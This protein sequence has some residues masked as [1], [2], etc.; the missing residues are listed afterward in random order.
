LLVWLNTVFPIGFSEKDLPA[1]NPE[2]PF[3]TESC[4]APV[5]SKIEKVY[6]VKESIE[7]PDS[8]KWL[9]RN[10]MLDALDRLWQ[11]H[12]YAMD[13]LRSSVGLRAY[14]QK[15]PLVEY[16]HEAFKMFSEMME[17]INKEILSNMFRSATSLSVFE[18]IL[19]SMPQNL[20][21][22]QIGQFGTEPEAG[23]SQSAQMH[24]GKQNAP[25]SSE[26]N[27]SFERSVPKVGRNEPCPCGSGKKFKKCCGK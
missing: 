7:S 8:L 15:N 14:A 5:I 19:S 20:V 24:G 2:Q 12:L 9:E 18:Q 13:H 17:A 11:D 16:R 4:V 25:Q 1:F 21:H 10:I 23:E 6:Q 26:V 3:E 27:V 22:G